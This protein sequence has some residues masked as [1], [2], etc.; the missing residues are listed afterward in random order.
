MF[1]AQA[2]N[3][4]RP[5]YGPAFL[6]HAAVLVDKAHRVLHRADRKTGRRTV[7]VMTKQFGAF[8]MSLTSWDRVCSA[9]TC[10]AQ[11]ER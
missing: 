2:F 10:L 8:E 5:T 11:G 1:E 7:L 6:A 9:K 4:D 3:D